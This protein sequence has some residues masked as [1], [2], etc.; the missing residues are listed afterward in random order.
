MTTQLDPISYIRFPKLDVATALSLAKILLHRVP[1]GSSSAI[2]KAASLVAASVAGLEAKW[3]QQAVPVARDLRPLARRVGSM[4]SA[5][6]DRLVTYESFPEDNPD[7]LRAMPIHDMLFAEGL[8]FLTLAFPRQHAESERRIRL[9]DSRGLAKDLEQL[10]GS[11]FVAALRATHQAH[12]DALGINKVSMPA[13]PVFI[14]DELRE[15]ADAIS[16]Y[17]LQL[18]ALARHDPEKREAVAIALSP[19][20]DFRAAAGRR[21]VTDED[22]EDDEDDA[23]VLDP[24]APAAN[25]PVEPDPLAT[26]TN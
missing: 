23:E 17:A 10:V 15:L 11:R 3:M 2:R 8:E 1:K 4:W 21:V 26:G 22:D 6:R 19:I 13:T 12:G 24:N 7:R 18:L 14:V 5:I 20:D 25:A 9:I 16:G